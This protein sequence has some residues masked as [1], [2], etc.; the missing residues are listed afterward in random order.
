MPFLEKLQCSA[1]QQKNALEP[2]QVKPSTFRMSLKSPL[3]KQTKNPQHIKFED[4]W[5]D[6]INVLK[7]LCTSQSR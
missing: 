6:E 7:I 2:T 5:K 3:N 4:T 1:E